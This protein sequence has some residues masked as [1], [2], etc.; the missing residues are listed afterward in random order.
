MASLQQLL[1]EE[2]IALGKFPISRNPAKLKQSTLP[3][4]SISLPIFICH[5][6]KTVANN[7][8][9][10]FSSKRVGS[11]RSVLG[12][13]NT[14]SSASKGTSRRDEP[15]IDEVAI[16]AVISI[17]SGYVGRC[18]NDVRFRENLREKCKSCLVRRKKEPDNG[19]FVNVEL[20]I[21][22]IEKLVEE[23]QG[24]TSSRELRMKTLRNSIQLLS[25]VDS[26]NSEKLKK[27]STCGT[28]N[29]HISACAQLYLALVYKL[30]KN[31]RISARHLLQAFCDSPFL[32]RTHLLPDLWEYFFLPH[33][34]HLKIWYTNEVEA[35]STTD[36]AKEKKMQALSKIYSQQMDKG[37]AEFALYYK[38]WLKVSVKGP[39]VLP[40]VPFPAKPRIGSSRRRSSDSYSSLPSTKNNLYR[41]VFG[42]SLERRSMDFVQ[43][44]GASINT[45]DLE[46]KEKL[47]T[48]EDNCIFVHKGDGRHRRTS[49]QSCGDS[50]A[51]LWPETQKTEY[52]RFLPC[53]TLPTE[54]LVDRKRTAKNGLVG[55]EENGHSNDLSRAIYIV[56]SS[57]ILS[58]CEIAIRVIAKAWLDSHGDPVVEAAL[59]EASIIE[60]MLEVLFASNDG[61]I[62]ELVIS[63]LAEFVGKNE[64][65]RQITL[66]YDPQLKNFMRLLRSSSL[67]LKAAVLLY[68][69]KPKAKQMISI[70]WVP[71]VLRVLEFGDQ[72]QT[73]FRVQC[74]PQVAAIY[75]LDHLLTGFDEDRNLENARQ[76]VSLGGLN[77]LAQQ[78]DSGDIHDRRNA[79]LI[80]SCCIRADGSCRNYLAEN[81]NMASLLELIVLE[82]RKNCSSCAFA[83]LADLLCLNRT[84]VIEL[85]DRL[86]QGWSSLNTT[87]ILLASLLRAPPEEY[88]LVAAILLQLDL[89]G[90]TME[91]SVYR[92]EAVEAMI[93]AL[94]CQICSNKVQEQSARAL[95]MLGGR[96]SFSGEASLERWLLQQAGFHET[97]G[98][99]F[100]SQEFVIDGFFMQSNEEEKATENWQKKVATVLFN[101]GKK[102]L[103]AG[104]SD[105]IANGIPSLARASM[106]T[107]TWMASFL[108]VVG[109]ENLH[110]MA[111][112]ILMPRLLESLDYNKDVEERVLAS[113]SLLCLFKSSEHVSLL[114]S[115][116][117]D[118]I[119][120]LQN[121]S[122]VTWTANEL[123]SILTSRWRH[124][125][126]PK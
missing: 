111:C 85:L 123:V 11:E 19:I 55:K 65:I 79:A 33:L 51:Q 88:P 113:Y 3:D 61:E 27:G 126:L 4:D 116:D 63:I 64:M 45:W 43:Q 101:S 86:N 16:R 36:Y 42:S 97:A 72:M 71:L 119:S 95:L 84:Q 41:E 76:V 93:A 107:V 24:T 29:S 48:D 81:L 62:L 125:Y 117:K 56:C 30:E 44:I 108:H 70:E 122:M 59:S 15:A 23:D 18:L 110:F 103:L 69:A 87:H 60:G 14:K 105:S 112:S 2:G 89:L 32:A 83:L 34:L 109:D 77:L 78:I 53:R 94:D 6:R 99:S 98:D 8:S 74:S 26:L 73:L 7:G 91:C 21:E 96:F 46:E 102:R 39:P 82:S 9:S 106:L 104:L 12:R 5:H 100:Q 10:V 47:C 66:N 75:F 118:L 13:S 67:F 1:A 28:P 115:W 120:K 92:E 22:S 40:T 80:M 49:R 31:D 57:D 35:L 90:N 25:V 17:L 37:T 52:F 124:Q 121:L 50:R 54:S 58:E 20:G 68:L 114:S 38:K